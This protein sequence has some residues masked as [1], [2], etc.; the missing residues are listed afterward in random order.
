MEK[1]GQKRTEVDK[2]WAQG[3]EKWENVD[4]KRGKGDKR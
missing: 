4:T 1:G 3:R 2:N